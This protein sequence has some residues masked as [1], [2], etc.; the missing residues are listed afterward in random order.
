MLTNLITGAA[1]VASPSVGE[2]TVGQ[3]RGWLMLLVTNL[4]DVVAV[5]VMSVV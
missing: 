5:L 3:A 2:I 1:P 4:L